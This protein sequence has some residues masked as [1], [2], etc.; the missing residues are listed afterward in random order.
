MSVTAEMLKPFLEGW[1]LKQII[2]AK[3][4]FYVDFKILDDLKTKDDNEVMAPVQLLFFIRHPTLN[5]FDCLCQICCPVALFFVT[6]A[7]QLVPIAIQLYQ[8]I[9]PDNPVYL[10]N[11]PPFTW[12]LAKMWFNHADASVH[13]AVSHLGIVRHS[14]TNYLTA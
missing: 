4:L 1:S 10:P 8:D 12:M 3:R 6:G 14:L 13:Q 7:K 2:E 5:N 9:A 11:D